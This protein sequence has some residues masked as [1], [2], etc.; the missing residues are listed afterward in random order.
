LRFDL[1]ARIFLEWVSYSRFGGK[2][3]NTVVL[4]TSPEFRAVTLRFDDNTDLT[5]ELRLGFTATWP[6]RIGK[7]DSPAVTCTNGTSE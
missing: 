2:T 6:V 5:M 3:I 4:F 7:R 1:F